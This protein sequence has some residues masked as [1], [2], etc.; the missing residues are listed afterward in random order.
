MVNMESELELVHRSLTTLLTERLDRIEAALSEQRSMIEHLAHQPQVP[1]AT[2][3][4]YASVETSVSKKTFKKLEGPSHSPSDRG[5]TPKR[6]VT[7]PIKTKP[8]VEEEEDPHKKKDEERK[9]Q[10]EAKTKKAEILRKIEDEKKR[11][12][13]VAKAKAEKRKAEEAER[14]TQAAAKKAADEERKIKEAAS[15]KVAAE[16]KRLKDS[17]VK[18]AKEEE[19]K[20]KE[21]EKKAKDEEKRAKELAA[22]QAKELVAKQAKEEKLKYEEEVKKKAEVRKRPEEAKKD[23]PKSARSAKDSKGPALKKKTPSLHD[24]ESRDS[25]QDSESTEVVLVVD[26][27]DEEISPSS[28]ELEKEAHLVSIQQEIDQIQ[29]VFDAETLALRPK[30]EISVGSKSA[31]SLM[32]TMGR[33]KLYLD[34]V[35]SSKIV[36]AHRLFFQ[37]RG[38]TLPENDTQAWEIIRTF[39]TEGHESNFG[40]S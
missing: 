6:P 35:P 18:K 25:A 9:K 17:A 31:L 1:L 10:E 40:K 26:V 39:L 15:K 28:S 5:Q 21:E 3:D 23:P 36:W 12:D 32:N 29:T 34:T 8:V 38:I 7:A 27:L 30:F 4:I 11:K 33:E 24:E 19:K 20:A 2:P 16:E 22:K 13:E 14:K 37:L